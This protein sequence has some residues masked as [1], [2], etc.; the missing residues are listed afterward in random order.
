MR[1]LLAKPAAS[2]MRDKLASGLGLDGAVD[3]TARSSAFRGILEMQHDA[4]MVLRHQLD[5]WNGIGVVQ[6]AQHD[7]QAA[8]DLADSQARQAAAAPKPAPAPVITPV[9]APQLQTRPPPPLVASAPVV[10]TPVQA[11][12][13]PTANP[14]MQWPHLLRL[15]KRSKKK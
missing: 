5:G 11:T 1:L 7:E 6:I 3:A 4:V 14:L 13:T 2:S 9:Q 15:L 12:N 8:R 10:A